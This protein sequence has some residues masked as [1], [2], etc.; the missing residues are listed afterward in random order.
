MKTDKKELRELILGMREAYSHGR[1]AMDYARQYAGGGANGNQLISTLIAYDLQ[2]GTYKEFARNNKVHH[3]RWCQQLASLIATVLPKGGSLLELG[4]GEATTLCGVVKELEGLVGSAHGFDLS[5]SRVYEGSAWL[6]ENNQNATL[7]V[8]DLFNIPLADQSVDVVF[9]S[10][11]I[12]PNGGREYDA[13]DECLRVARTAVVLV[14]PIYELASVEAKRRMEKLGYIRNLRS[15][16]DQ[17]PVNIKDYRLLD[18]CDNPLNPSGVLILVKPASSTGNGGHMDSLSWWQ[19]PHT[20][21]PLLEHKDY[22]VSEEMGVVYPKLK[23]I[24]LLDL[25]HMVIASKCL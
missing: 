25:G 13:I 6:S 5:W 21:A 7:F 9:S 11:S 15:V 10:H 18:H 24:P 20:G 22:L 16:A 23:G 8:G 12:E 1:N 2:A 4:T 17:F 19:C 14:E 3:A